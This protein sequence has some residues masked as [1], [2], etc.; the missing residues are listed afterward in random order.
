MGKRN[1]LLDFDAKRNTVVSVSS[2]L[3]Q[4]SSKS[5]KN[6]DS[7]SEDRQTHRRRWHSELIICPMLCYSN[8]TE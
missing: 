6:R 7:E 4:V 5:D 2:R 3:C 1:H 8:G